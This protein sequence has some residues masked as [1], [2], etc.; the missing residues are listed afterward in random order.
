MS[1][2]S[3][4]ELD[5]SWVNSTISSGTAKAEDLITR[6]INFIADRNE[7]LATEITNE[8]VDVIKG[9]LNVDDEHRDYEQ[10]VEFLS[11][12]FDVM[13]AIAPKNC[14]F[15]GHEGD[16]ACYGFWEFEEV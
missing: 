4:F 16:P 11:H 13:D 1:Y 14:M 6:I 7:A 5:E 12:L 3:L 8:W 2:K 15:G 9:M 10:E